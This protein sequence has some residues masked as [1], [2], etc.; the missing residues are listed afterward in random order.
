LTAKLLLASKVRLCS[1]A[2]PTKT[3]KFLPRLGGRI[4]YFS[5][6]DSFGSSLTGTGPIPV[7]AGSIT[8]LAGYTVGSGKYLLVGTNLG[9]LVQYDWTNKALKSLIVVVL[10]TSTQSFGRVV[11]DNSP[12]YGPVA[13]YS[14]NSNTVSNL[15]VQVGRVNL[16]NPDVFEEFDSVPITG[17]YRCLCPSR[18]LIFFSYA[19][20]SLSLSLS[21]SL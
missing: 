1:F 17:F 10:G 20:V 9:I 11:V 12:A 6:S 2:Y 19:S 13:F 21:L 3:N 5:D 15:N 14:T 18:P 7:L 16:G 8:A 4:V